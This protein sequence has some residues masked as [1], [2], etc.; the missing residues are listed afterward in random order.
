MD[1]EE[2]FHEH[3]ILKHST[4][5]GAK[6]YQDV[7]FNFLKY[8]PEI[9]E[10]A[11]HVL[12]NLTDK[13]EGRPFLS[14]HIRRGDFVTLRWL[15]NFEKEDA[16]LRTVGNVVTELKQWLSEYQDNNRDYKEV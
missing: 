4:P 9:Y 16:L 2:H 6:Q 5:E 13:L 14:M 8:A 15:D 12:Q 1:S 7:V 10:A 3:Y 11:E